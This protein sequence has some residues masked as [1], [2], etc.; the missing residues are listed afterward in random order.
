MARTIRAV[1]RHVLLAAVLLG[2]AGQAAAE[3]YYYAVEVKGVLCGHVRISA[4]PLGEGGRNLTLLKHE[5]VVRGRLPG[6]QSTAGS[7]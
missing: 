5:V 4:S 2:F 6:V 3:E 7:P 1:F